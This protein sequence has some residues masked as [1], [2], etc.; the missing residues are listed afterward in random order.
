MTLG[1]FSLS[2]EKDGS[3]QII[4]EDYDIEAFGGADY[5]TTYALDRANITKFRNILERT[6]SGTLKEMITEEFGPHLNKHP[7]SL[8]FDQNGIKYKLF[9]WVSYS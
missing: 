8:W 4:I 5:E 2:W 1:T 3:L 7:M 6:H 9:T